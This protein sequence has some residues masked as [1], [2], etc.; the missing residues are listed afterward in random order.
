MIIEK[1]KNLKSAALLCNESSG[2]GG[3]DWFIIS[4]SNSRPFTKEHELN[5]NEIKEIANLK[6]NGKII[7]DYCSKYG[8][9]YCLP[10]V[11]FKQDFKN[12]KEKY[13]KMDEYFELE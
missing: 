10:G 3:K 1:L 6:R 7:M 4:L 12:H 2:L 8:A 9:A 5:D 11:S 13:N